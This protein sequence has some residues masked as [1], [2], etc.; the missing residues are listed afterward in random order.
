MEY[1]P[2]QKVATP[3]I[4]AKDKDDKQNNNSGSSS[5]SLELDVHHPQTSDGNDLTQPLTAKDQRKVQYS[6]LFTV[7]A[8]GAALIR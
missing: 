1:D 4:E 8:A 7:L 3:S 6:D 2:I 5:A